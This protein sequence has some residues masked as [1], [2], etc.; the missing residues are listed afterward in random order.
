L[1]YANEKEI[2]GGLNQSKCVL[3][4]EEFIKVFAPS[5]FNSV[6]F[7][8]EFKCS[9]PFN[10]LLEDKD[11]DIFCN[12]D[13][14]EGGKCYDLNI[15]DA[16]DKLIPHCSMA[17]D[18]LID[19]ACSCPAS[20]PA[21]ITIT[22]ENYDNMSDILKEYLNYFISACAGLNDKEMTAALLHI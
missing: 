22:V 8:K 14:Y 11:I 12:D 9:M 21:K 10:K 13:T 2:L 20:D 18:V 7:D 16:V 1:S 4:P 17:E 15:L 19:R 3:S 6:D 5:M